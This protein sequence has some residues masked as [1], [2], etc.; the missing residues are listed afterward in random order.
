MQEQNSFRHG[1]RRSILITQGRGPGEH[2]ILNKTFYSLPL[3]LFVCV[4]VVN[5]IATII[6]QSKYKPTGGVV[7]IYEG[8][9]S[10]VKNVDIAS[11]LLINVLSTLL[12]GAS[13]FHAASCCSY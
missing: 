9:C 4:L 12:L 11:H 6:V 2:G 5:I 7:S 3:P 10:W 1:F 13:I 8:S